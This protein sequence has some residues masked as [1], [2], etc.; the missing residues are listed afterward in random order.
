MFEFISRL[1]LDAHHQPSVIKNIENSWSNLWYWAISLGPFL[2]L[3][4][5]KSFWVLLSSQSYNQKF[6]NTDSSLFRTS[7]MSY[8][9]RI[10]FCVIPKKGHFSSAT[11]PWKIML[12]LDADREPNWQLL[13]NS[14]WRRYTAWLSRPL[15][16]K[17]NRTWIRKSP[18]QNRLRRLENLD[19]S[20]SY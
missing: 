8:L 10:R 7:M 19:K 13:S 3:K 16:N 2:E 5:M 6:N 11:I 4:L 9:S 15:P 18:A 17:L 14:F 20:K 1:N 12:K